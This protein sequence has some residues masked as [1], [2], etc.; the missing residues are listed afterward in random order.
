M[1]TPRASLTNPTRQL[2]GG[3]AGGYDPACAGRLGAQALAVARA[4][5]FCE[6]RT[7]LADELE[8]Q[9]TAQAPAG[10]G[11]PINIDELPDD[12][13]RLQ[14]DQFEG[15]FE[16]LLYLIRV[17]E[18]DIF[19][20]PI[21]R[22]TEQ[23]L[24]FMDLMQ[25]NNLDVAG[26]FLVMAATLIQIKSKM[27]LPIDVPAEEE[28]EIIEEDPRM[29][30]VE[31]LLEYRKF[32]DL[33]VAL[34]DRQE[35]RGDWFG[36]SVKPVIERDESEEEELLDVGLYDLIKAVRAI[37]RYMTEG[38]A[39]QVIGEGSSV[40]EKI[41]RIETLLT[42]RESI[43]WKDLFD[44][45]Q[46]R[47]E[48]VCC[49]LAILELCRMRRIRAHQHQNFGDIRIVP[50]GPEEEQPAYVAVEA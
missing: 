37:L 18:I 33:S 34:G 23:Y 5:S 32:R 50:R 6:R 29:E 19:D 3:G 8:Q 26:E 30:L 28:E 20:I 15:P 17:Q 39:H 43:T 45:C 16:M 27:L 9:L 11:A 14:L 35:K 41:S 12:V 42:E 1:I 13:L 2:R 36:R 24:R 31:K 47:V 49:L 25:G 48:L 10:E 40:D 21:L 7:R 4:V 46:S 38:A 22:V 44:E